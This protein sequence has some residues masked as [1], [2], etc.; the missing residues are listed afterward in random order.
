LQPQS[1]QDVTRILE[2]LGTGQPGAA[3]E[4]FPLVYDELRA[5]AGAYF[6]GRSAGHTL[7][8]T[9][10]VHEAYV[11]LVGETAGRARDR[12]HFLA[13]AARVMRQILVDHARSKYRVKRGGEQER[14][15]LEGTLLATDARSVDLI[16]LNDALD[17]LGA[18]DASYA[19]I[20]E[21]RFFAGLSEDDASAALGISRPTAS[22]AWRFARAWLIRE[23]WPEAGS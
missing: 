21:L 12:A 10:L 2:R 15:A 9:A 17:R 20:V 16:E 3:E 5:V 19:R 8:P 1:A 13:L 23:L 18:V 7:Q 22:R 14:V 11:K 4:L 6:R